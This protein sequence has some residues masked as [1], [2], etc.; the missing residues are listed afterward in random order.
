MLGGSPIGHAGEAAASTTC[1][2]NA[3]RERTRLNGMR[4][5]ARSADALNTSRQRAA[6]KAAAAAWAAPPPLFGNSKR[7]VCALDDTTTAPRALETMLGDSSA[8]VGGRR[9][10]GGANPSLHAAAKAAF[11]STAVDRDRDDEEAAPAAGDAADAAANVQ[12]PAPAG[13]KRKR[14]AGGEA[15]MRFQRPR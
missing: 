5:M 7:L 14:V 13:Q 4:F 1:A 9:S 8:A 10:W 15:S 12:E 11:A 3:P 2:A 6:E